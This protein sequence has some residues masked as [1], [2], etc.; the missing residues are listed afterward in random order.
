M[1]TRN[2]NQS[3]VGEVVGIVDGFTSVGVDVMDTRYFCRVY[4]LL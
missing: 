3:A 4:A 1:L 2:K